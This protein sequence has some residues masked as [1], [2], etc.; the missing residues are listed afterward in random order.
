MSG[1]IHLVL[2]LASLVLA[3]PSC[4]TTTG[5]LPPSDAGKK[6]QLLPPQRKLYMGTKE[7]RTE[8]NELLARLEESRALPSPTGWK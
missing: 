8:I 5:A 3:L 4:R 6:Q 1:R 2:L 7:T